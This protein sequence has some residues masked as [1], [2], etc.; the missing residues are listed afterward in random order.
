VGGKEKINWGEG[1]SSLK[2]IE[3]VKLNLQCLERWGYAK[4]E[5]D[6]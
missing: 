2:K 6:N 5:N 3:R 4:R 1:G